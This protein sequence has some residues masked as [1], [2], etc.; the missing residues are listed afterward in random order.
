LMARVHWASGRHAPGRLAEVPGES[1][2][3]TVNSSLTSSPNAIWPR[4]PNSGV[5]NV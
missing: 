2:S 3:S 5:P 4:W 1:G